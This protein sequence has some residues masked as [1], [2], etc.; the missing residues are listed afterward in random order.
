MT[1]IVYNKNHAIAF[2][3]WLTTDFQSNHIIILYISYYIVFT[4][5]FIQIISGYL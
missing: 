2:D 1:Y 3:G 4:W 5:H